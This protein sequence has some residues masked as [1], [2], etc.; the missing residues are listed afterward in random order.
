MRE[1]K[2]KTSDMDEK[3]EKF[4]VVTVELDY[5]SIGI[6]EKLIKQQPELGCSSVEQ[7]LEGLFQI[8]ENEILEDLKSEKGETK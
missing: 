8:K 4:K 5:E 7:Y 2:K 6:I 3:D 1:N